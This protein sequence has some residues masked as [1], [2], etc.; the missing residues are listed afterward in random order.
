MNNSVLESFGRWKEFLGEH[1]DKAQSMG[2]ND[3]QIANVAAKM[4]EFLAD[5]V[6]PKNPEERLLKELW[7]VGDNEERRTIAKL[8]V[9]LADRAH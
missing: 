5:K 1:V 6:D 7:D 2:F 3:D 9:K 8:M 4:G